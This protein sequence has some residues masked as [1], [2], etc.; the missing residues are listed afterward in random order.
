MAQVC[1]VIQADP[2]S[3]AIALAALNK[4][5]LQIEKTAS[6]GK[7]LVISEAPS[8]SQL[9]AVIAGDPDKL[10]SA[11]ATLIGAGRTINVV[12]QTFSAS[13][14]VVAYV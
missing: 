13:H 10:A 7:F 3:L 6:A 4:E 5:V 14:Y 1:N 2:A 9:F 11:L 12:T 8:T